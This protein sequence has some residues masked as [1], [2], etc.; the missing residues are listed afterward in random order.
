MGAEDRAMAARKKAAAKKTATGKA[1]KKASTKKKVTKQSGAKKAPTKKATRKK[2][3]SKR[4]AASLRWPGTT[5]TLELVDRDT[6]TLGA[7]LAYE[8][9]PAIVVRYDE[10]GGKA[11]KKTLRTKT[12][13]AA[14][15]TQNVWRSAMKL[16]LNLGFG[17]SGPNP[18]A[19]QWLTATDEPFSCRYQAFALDR[20]NDAV[21]VGDTGYLRHIERNTRAQTDVLLGK[22]VFPVSLQCTPRGDA[23]AL[24]HKN[25]PAP[26]G[27]AFTP[28]ASK[29]WLM[30]IAKITDD[31]QVRSIAHTDYDD[32]VY[33]GT[34][35]VSD[36]G[37]VLGP[38]AGG[39]AIYDDKG[40]IVEEHTLSKMGYDD[41]MG[42]ISP[43]ARWLALTGPEGEVRIIDRDKGSE[44]ASR[45]RFRS[46]TAIE[47]ADDG[48]V[49]VH[50]HGPSDWGIYE[51]AKG[52]AKKISSDIWA[53]TTPDRKSVIRVVDGALS[54]KPVGAR[55]GGV[56]ASFPMLSGRRTQTRFFDDSTAVIRTGANIVAEVDLERL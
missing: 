29:R 52:G 19:L 38:M 18:S 9:G 7:S 40:R 8:R 45:A 35:S 46:V 51:L 3:A 47:I 26:F 20:R 13:P 22:T 31:L 10:P 27:P 11:R 54:V 33:L 56:S 53:T 36:D 41:P 49:H 25:Q 2:A 48:A 32:E 6:G 15:A 43:S 34:L 17:V 39:A 28:P 21:W 37:Q 5:S 30:C 24:L 4:K 14:V 23:Y 44:T 50:A 12:K 42:A 16:V 1:A 55:S